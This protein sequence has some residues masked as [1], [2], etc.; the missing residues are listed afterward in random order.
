ML[1]SPIVKGI[2]L[3]YRDV[4]E[5]MKADESLRMANEKADENERKF[6]AILEQTS[7]GITV[8]DFEG[9]YVLVNP[10][11]CEMTAYSEE[12]LLKMKIFDL[13]KSPQGVKID[14]GLFGKPHEYILKRKDNSTFPTEIVIKP[15][16]IGDD[17]LLLGMITN[18]TERKKT[19]EL[20][21]LQNAKLIHAKEKAE[22]S[23]QLKSEFIHNMSHEIRTPLNSILGFS[24]ILNED[25]L[26]EKKQNQYIDIIQNS[27]NQLLTIIDDILEISKLS[28]KQ[29]ELSEKQICINDL[30]LELFSVFDLKAKENNTPLYVKKGLKN[31]QSK[32]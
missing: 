13:L 17:T 3:N 21:I 5:K 27:G 11:F 16:K 12:E 18:I 25:D 20:I 4:T 10:A 30:F 28:T 15:V 26:S 14:P 8:A 24:S 2:I 19:E 32:I 9:N 6:K 22:E 31:S 29:V 1:D 7:E 23:D